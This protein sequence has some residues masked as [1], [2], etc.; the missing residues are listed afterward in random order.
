MLLALVSVLLIVPIASDM[1]AR[2]A[3][4]VF[5]DLDERS[6]RHVLEPRGEPAGHGAKRGRR[7]PRLLGPASLANMAKLA[8]HAGR[9]DEI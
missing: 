3:G 6:V 5:D 7:Q 4:N 9:S 1:A 2:L 8:M